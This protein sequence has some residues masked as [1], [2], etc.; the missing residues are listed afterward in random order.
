MKFL[1]GKNT[2]SICS[3]NNPH[4]FDWE[5]LVN[6]YKT[7]V[8]PH[9]RVLEIGASTQQRTDDLALYCKKLI[10]VE[11]KKDRL[12][13][14]KKNIMYVQADW[15]ELS[16]KIKKNSIDI[17][18]A[19]HVIEHVKYDLKA[20]NELYLV[21]K[22]GG[23][24][25]INTPNRERLTRSIIELFTGKRTFPWWEHEREYTEEDLNTLISKSLFKRFAISGHVLGI[26]GGPLYIYA[27]KVP[28]QMK[29]YSNFWQ[30]VLYRP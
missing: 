5:H 27:T 1:L 24:A 21:L 4:H 17:A 14:N 30:I 8:K 19:S 13:K 29:K 22:K 16:K 3:V 18:V 23:V 9:H 20:I 10:G 7:Y 6:T 2:L 28:K 15:Q 25:L 26:H 11:L 12:L